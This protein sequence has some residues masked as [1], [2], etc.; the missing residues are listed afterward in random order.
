MEPPF[1]NEMSGFCF[2]VFFGF[3]NKMIATL[4]RITAERAKGVIVK[5]LK[6][7]RDLGVFIYAAE[8]AA[9]WQ[10]RISHP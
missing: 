7:A 5:A 6:V 2:A 8:R 10:R 1:L 3:G 4:S 9:L